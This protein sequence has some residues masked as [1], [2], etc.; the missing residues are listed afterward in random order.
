MR[1][2]PQSNPLPAAREEGKAAKC[3]A[4]LRSI[5]QVTQMYRNEEPG[6]KMLWYRHG[7]DTPYDDTGASWNIYPGANLYTPW[8]F[9]G[10]LA[11]VPRTDYQA[12]SN[13][14]PTQKR[15]LTIFSPSSAKLETRV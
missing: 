15:P 13:I 14:C 7:M 8:I 5:L 3:L 6:E 12:D 9:G 4:N 1:P 11:P 10:F 2:T